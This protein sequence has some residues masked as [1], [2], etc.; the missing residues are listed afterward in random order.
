MI[1]IT[2]FICLFFL[3]LLIPTS[4]DENKQK[5]EKTARKEQVKKMK[6]EG[7]LK[8]RSLSSYT[9]KA[10]QLIVV[11]KNTVFTDEIQTLLDTTFGALI[12]PFRYPPLPKFEIVN[13]DPTRFKESHLRLRNVLILEFS[14]DVKEGAPE[15]LIKKDYYARKQ[16]ITEIRAANI[17]DLTNKLILEAD[18]LTRMYDE[19]E[20][21]REFARLKKEDN[22]VISN[23]LIKDFGISLKV[24]KKARYEINKKKNFAKIMFPDRSR[25]MEM[26][27]A[28]S[29]HSS[30]ANFI[31]SGLM[32]WEIPYNK[33]SQ[34][35]P[36]FLL[37]VRDTLLKYNALHEIPGVYMGTQDHPA[38]LPVHTYMQIGSIQG[39]EFRGLFKF[40]GRIEP[41]GGKFWSFH[42][43]HPKRKTIMA[44][45][46]YL[47][48]PPTMSPMFD[49]RRIQAAIYSLTIE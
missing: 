11:A 12:E 8:G 48:A 9:G 23:Q 42:F 20:W 1:R 39:Y 25:Q 43:I 4:C 29:N 15:M 10:G 37:K 38:I 17:N 28:G 44:I 46:G 18:A 21:K 47:D 3:L 2:I 27:A 33:K 34:F 5:F 40:T 26:K 24:P 35:Q 6:K 49:L 13:L 7:V 41:S 30:K 19:M 36:D 32:I 31:Y 45:S 22:S 16:I 14:D